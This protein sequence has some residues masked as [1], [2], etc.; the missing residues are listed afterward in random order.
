MP[1]RDPAEWNQA[2]MEL[3]ALI[4]TPRA[5]RCADCPLREHCGALARGRPEAFPPAGARRATERVRR[6]IVLIARNGALLMSRLGGGLLDGLW[7]P[8]GATRVGTET[9]REVLERELVRLGVRAEL[10]PA[11]T[12]LRHRITHREIEVEIWRGTLRAAVPRRASLRFVNPRA[13]EVA[14]TALASRA[15]GLGMRA[16]EPRGAGRGARGRSRREPAPRQ[17]SARDR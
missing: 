9:A 8:P 1:R 2:L 17:R 4:C 5:P 16:G 7:E 12:T 10:E 3:G 14:L 11:R 13:P 15:A 6:A